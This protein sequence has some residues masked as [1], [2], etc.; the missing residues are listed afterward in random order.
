[1]GWTNL[2]GLDD[3]QVVDAAEP[4]THGCS[5][6]CRAEGHAAEEPRPQL[7][8]PARRHKGRHLGPGP[9]VL[10]ISTGQAYT[11]HSQQ[12]LQLSNIFSI[13]QLITIFLFSPNNQE[14]SLTLNLNHYTCVILLRSNSV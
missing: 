14:C 5:E 3:G 4:G 2:R 9:A 10:P 8:M 6:S 12:W 13:I 11:S 1:M 7:V